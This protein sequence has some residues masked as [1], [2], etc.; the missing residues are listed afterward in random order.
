MASDTP[1]VR[2]DASAPLPLAGQISH[3]LAWLIASGE[4]ERGAQLPPVRLLAEELGVNLHTVRAAYQQLEADGLIA[5]R[6]GRRATVLPYDRTRVASASPDLPS[7]TV[8]AIIPAFAPF[9]APMLDGIESA[10]AGHA[11]LVF[12]CNAHESSDAVLTYLDRLIAQRVDG[13]IITFPGLPTDTPLPPPGRRP[14]I[15]FVDSPNAPGPG[16]EFDLEG[17]ARRATDHL[18]EHGHRRIG[19]LTP[20]IEHA[21]VA[22]KFAGYERALRAAGLDVDPR[23][24]ASVPDFTIEAGRRGADR[25]IDLDDRPTGIVAVND[26]LA[27][28]AM[29]AAASRGMRIPDDIALI[30]NDDIDIA[31]IVRPALTTVALPTRRA[32]TEAAAMLQRLIAGQPPEPARIVLETRLVTRETCGCQ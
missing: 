21:N 25:L 16:V 15:V 32:G 27:L 20:P 26:M 23:L 10:S 13:I 24:V 2:V 19:F 6:Q 22:P 29:H 31:A 30:G 8:G 11:A 14:S 12:T 18:I 3:Q 9:Y 5:V 7:F 4:L 1:L 17:S 28:G